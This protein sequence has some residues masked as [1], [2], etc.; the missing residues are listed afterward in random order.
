[1]SKTY[2]TEDFKRWGGEGGRKSRRTLTPEQAR[3]MVEAKMRKRASKA[4]TATV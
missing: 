3:K 4:A 1:M 2:T